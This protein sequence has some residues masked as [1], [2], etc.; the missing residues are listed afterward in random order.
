M[1]IIYCFLSMVPQAL[2]SLPPSRYRTARLDYISQLPLQ[3]AK[4]T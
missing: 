1:Y 3:P 2:L 4:P